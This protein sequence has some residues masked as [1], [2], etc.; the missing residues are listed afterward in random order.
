MSRIFD[1]KKLRKQTSFLK[2]KMNM[3]Q[4]ITASAAAEGSEVLDLD[5]RY[6][7]L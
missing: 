2:L 6:I 4:P 5:T 7:I 3:L 1:L